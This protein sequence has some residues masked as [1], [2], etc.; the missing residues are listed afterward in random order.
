LDQVQNFIATSLT[1]HCTHH[2][3]MQIILLEINYTEFN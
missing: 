3:I 1:S 2:K